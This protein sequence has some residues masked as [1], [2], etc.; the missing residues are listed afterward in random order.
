MPDPRQKETN[1]AMQRYISKKLFTSEHM[2]VIME[3]IGKHI[4]ERKMVMTMVNQAAR[5]SPIHNQVHFVFLPV[6]DMGR[7][8]RFYS[9]LLG[10]PIHPVEG[11]LYNLETNGDAGIVLDSNV[12]D[13]FAPSSHPM[14]ALHAPDIQA[15]YE[16]VQDMGAVLVTHGIVSFGD[17]SFFVFMDADGNRITVVN[18]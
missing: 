6:R 18:K 4:K 2:Y 13:G 10:L 3:I 5:M 1:R 17:I 9:K 8:V 15:A 16:F 7:A 12:G 11:T 14:F